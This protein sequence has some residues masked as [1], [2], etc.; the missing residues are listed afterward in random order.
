MF[1]TFSCARFCLTV[2]SAAAIL[3]AC[4]KSGGN[5]TSVLPPAA[6][7]SR[8]QSTT[9]G[10]AFYI[11]CST[12]KN[13]DGTQQAPF[14]AL[15][16][17]DA[18][19]LGPGDQLLFHRGTR[20]AGQL[21][22]SGSGSN[23][24]PIVVDAYGVGAQPV[25]DGTAAN[26]SVILLNEQ[27]YWEIRNLELV[28]GKFNGIE[29][30]GTRRERHLHYYHLINLNLHNTYQVDPNG[31]FRAG[32]IHFKINGIHETAS[33]ILIDGVS[34]HDS[35][36][37]T[38]IWVSVG[39]YFPDA[40]NACKLDAT[41]PLGNNVIVRNS[42]VHD[43]DGPGIVLLF[44]SNG[45]IENNVVYKTGGPNS[46]NG[47]T[48]I[49]ELCAHT[50]TVQNNESYLHDSPIS[51][52]GDFDIDGYNND[53]VLQYNY[54][55]D[56]GGYCIVG[57]GDPAA[58]SKN[59]IFRYNVCSNDDRSSLLGIQ[60]EV[61]GRQGL[62]G[63]Q[64]Y[65]NTFYSNPVTGTAVFYFNISGT[66]ITRSFI[67]NNIVYA[68]GSQML[69]IGS[70]SAPVSG[71]DLVVDNNIYWSTGTVTP[72][73]IWNDTSYNGLSA[74]QTGTGQ[75]T[76]SF[77]S[78]PLMINPTYHGAG[79]SPSAFTLKRASPARGTGT[80]VCTGITG[81]SMG[82]RDFFGNP[83]PSGSGYDIGADQEP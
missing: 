38:G 14:N 27:E 5:G 33:D 24:S 26:D 40:V 44:V 77:N 15:S 30:E 63:W 79:R 54:A 47:A 16:S 66:T 75:D 78:D 50:L 2:L 18:L 72:S 58:P 7:S 9:N 36:A 21:N 56:A 53:N 71:S 12:Q 73:W 64:I 37:N 60:G 43:V 55:H 13:G 67:K 76:H 23:G 25:I 32:E 51:D 81:C 17:V 42:T 82:T 83:L 45:L 4:G 35:P 39:G 52:G 31:P 28:G 3:A 8:I 46:P 11:D 65:N 57:D 70:Q 61:Y 69:Q 6:G 49:W 29:I 1:Q 80:N 62:D 10:R 19:Q 59:N 22:P 41:P 20:C 34:A 74:F 48:G 68:T